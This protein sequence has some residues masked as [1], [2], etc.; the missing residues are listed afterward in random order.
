MNWAV[1]QSYRDIGSELI[2][3]RQ[4]QSDCFTSLSVKKTPKFLTPFKTPEKYEIEDKF[5]G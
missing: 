5:I 2:L 4:F 1:S 3:L